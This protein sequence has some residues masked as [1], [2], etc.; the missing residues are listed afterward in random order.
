MCARIKDFVAAARAADFSVKYRNRD[1]R[2]SLVVSLFDKSP[3]T[4][5]IKQLEAIAFRY[6]LNL[7]V[8]KKSFSHINVVVSEGASANAAP[9]A[10]DTTD[11]PQP[12]TRLPDWQ[13]ALVKQLKATARGRD[14]IQNVLD[15]DDVQGLDRDLLEEQLA[16]QENLY[17]VILRR[18]NHYRLNAYL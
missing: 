13:Y 14:R 7:E 10:V 6:N 1:G 9:F 16:A 4:D 12:P 11:A 18:V 8:T 3:G 5:S 15:G 2:Y 17:D